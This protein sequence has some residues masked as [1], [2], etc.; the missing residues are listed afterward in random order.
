MLPF[1]G[2]NL[3]CQ[4]CGY[5][6]QGGESVCPRCQYSPRQRGLRVALAFLMGVVISMTV[7]MFLPLLAPLLV[8]IAA[9][10]FVLCFGT[11]VISFLA[12]PYRFGTVFLRL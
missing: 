2:G 7:V 1:R 11:I 5:G 3:D 12:T 8:G 4:R 6:L 9:L 10:S